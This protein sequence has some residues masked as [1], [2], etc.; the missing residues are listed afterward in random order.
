M[1]AA[2][3]VIATVLGVFTA[4]GTIASWFLRGKNRGS[5]VPSRQRPRGAWE[6]VTAL[7]SITKVSGD[8]YIETMASS[9]ARAAAEAEAYAAVARRVKLPF[10]SA[11]AY[12]LVGVLAFW[13][14]F[15]VWLLLVC[16]LGVFVFLVMGFFNLMMNEGD[17]MSIH[18]LVEQDNELILRNPFAALKQHARGGF[19]GNGYADGRVVL[20][21]LHFRMAKIRDQRDELK[22]RAAELADRERSLERRERALSANWSLRQS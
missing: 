4:A 20:K 2:F 9:A 1:W 11:C 21:A 10:W 14:S 8:P 12:L 16:V 19:K 22:Q 13:P 18:T 6:R 15:D 3:Q 17:K 5:R 7:S